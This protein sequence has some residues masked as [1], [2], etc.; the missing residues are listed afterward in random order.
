MR[1]SRRR[2]TMKRYEKLTWSIK[3]YINPSVLD[4][5]S[6]AKPMFTPPPPPP[7]PASHER[8]AQE[9]Q[10]PS[11]SAPSKEFFAGSSSPTRS[12]DD[13]LVLQRHADPSSPHGSEIR[14]RVE[15]SSV[16]KLVHARKHERWHA[17][18][19]AHERARAR[20]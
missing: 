7:P 14:G 4:S 20:A 18:T 6:A 2:R 16:C 10:T 8:L 1:M 19:H 11:P 9:S 15:L 13:G 17:S 12:G 5:F 3:T